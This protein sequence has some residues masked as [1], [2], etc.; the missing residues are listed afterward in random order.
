MFHNAKFDSSFI[1]KQNSTCL[2]PVVPKLPPY[3]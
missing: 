3:S 1:A 2:I